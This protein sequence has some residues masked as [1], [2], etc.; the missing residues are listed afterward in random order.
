MPQRHA[1]RFDDLKQSSLKTARAWRLKELWRTFGSCI[2][3]G[4]G[5]AFFK[6]WY[7]LVMASKLEPVK[8]VART[9]Q[10]HLAGV[11]AFLAHG[12]CNALAEG[13]NSRIQL[14]VQKACG[15]RNRERLKTDILFHFG[16][17]NLDPIM[18][19]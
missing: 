6:R 8:K 5:L 9:L 11:V 14:L 10:A 7:H 16:G 15:Y 17:L 1:D 12:F 13:I 3:V 19:Q 4:D 18:A 2:D